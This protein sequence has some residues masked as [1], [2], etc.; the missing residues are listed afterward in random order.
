[1]RGCQVLWQA[2]IQP[3]LAP[4]RRGRASGRV[5]KCPHGDG[6]RHPRRFREGLRGTGPRASAA[7]LFVCWQEA[8]G[9][10][11]WDMSH[12]E[13]PGGSRRDRASKDLACPEAFAEFPEREHR[14]P[15]HLDRLLAEIHAIRGGDGIVPEQRMQRAAPLGPPLGGGLRLDRLDPVIA[16]LIRF[17]SYSPWISSSR[18]GTFWASSTTTHSP[19]FTAAR[20]VRMSDGFER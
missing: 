1:M 17:D 4:W 8:P 3:R 6:T 10:S 20:S 12:Q 18:S 16:K 7:G 13:A 9:G 2:G 11:R 19:G 15:V 5:A 14:Q